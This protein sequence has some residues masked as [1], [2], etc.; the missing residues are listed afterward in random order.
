MCT[1]RYYRQNDCPAIRIVK[2]VKVFRNLQKAFDVI[3]EVF[4]FFVKVIPTQKVEVAIG[5]Y[6]FRI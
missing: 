1:V 6:I 5:D 2:C 3:L 4:Y